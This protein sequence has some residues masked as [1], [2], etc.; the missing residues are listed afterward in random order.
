M[1]LAY[2]LAMNRNIRGRRIIVDVERGRTVAGWRPRRLGGGIGGES[3]LSRHK[4]SS[5]TSATVAEVLD[6]DLCRLSRLSPP[7]PPPNLLGLQP[8]T[9]L[10]LSTS[11]I[12]RLPLIF[13]FIASL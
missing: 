5:N 2:K 13:L 9:V 11:T 8:A 1:K 12:I 4:S 3:R 6:D 10:P 7:I